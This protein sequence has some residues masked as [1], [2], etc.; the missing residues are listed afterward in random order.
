MRTEVDRNHREQDGRSDR[1]DSG[2]ENQDMCCRY[3]G[4]APKRRSFEK[5]EQG[6]KN[7]PKATR[8]KVES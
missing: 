5:G 1:S 6:P 3:A 4:S 7:E 2:G 8:D